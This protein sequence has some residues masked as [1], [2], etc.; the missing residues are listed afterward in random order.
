MAGSSAARLLVADDDPD[1]LE[2]VATVL[3]S[4]GYDVIQARDGED[5]LRLAR[6]CDPDLLLL[7][8]DMPGTNGYEVCRQ[9]QDAGPL[10]PPVIF[11]TASGDATSRV[12]GL[13]SGAVD[14]VVKPFHS[15]EL[16]ARVRAALRTKAARDALAAEA[17]TDGL[18]GLVNRRQVDLRAEE[19]VALSRRHSRPL[20]CLM[21]D[22]DHFKQVNDT[23]G[24]AAGDAILRELAERFR[25]AS[26]TSDVPGRYGGE[27]FILL[28][29][30]TDA[31]GALAMAEKIRVSVAER[32]F[33]IPVSGAGDSAGPQAQPTT[34][35]EPHPLSIPVRVSVG[36]A[37]RDPG[38]LDA[39]AL[40][41]A[42]DAALYEAKRQGRDRVRL[43]PP[44]LGII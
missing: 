19:L 3:H 14:Y 15:D 39:E 5:A 11:L 16:T 27:E 43:A 40:Y 36:V 37:A 23:Y 2:L 24:H 33:V 30:E 9:L 10:A 1:I 28:L 32:P 44:A 12:A 25:A 35:G 31:A 29:P 17:S 20:S 34:A 18:T 7:D 26:R 13:D 41:A 4:A 38:M 42:A 22:V 6:Q 21:V 8:V